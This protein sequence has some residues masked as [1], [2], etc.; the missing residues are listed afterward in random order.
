MKLPIPKDKLK[1]TINHYFN[2]I[3]MRPKIIDLYGHIQE[4]NTSLITDMSNM[5]YRFN[6][7]SNEPIILNWDTSNVV[8]MSHM[9]EYCRQSFILLFNNTSKV[10]DMSYM[11]YYNNLEYSITLD[12]SNVTNMS[13]MFAYCKN[14][15]QPLNFSNTSN[16]INMSFMFYNASEFNQPLNFDT[17]SAQNMDKM[18]LNAINFNQPLNFD[19]SN[20]ITYDE[21]F[22]G[23]NY[24]HFICFKIKNNRYYEMNSDMQIALNNNEYNKLV[25]IFILNIIDQNIAYNIDWT[26]FNI[27]Q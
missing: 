14:F 16:V 13:Y 9:F 17:C 23:I 10:T 4:W 5:F 25:L 12:T 19:T 26:M 7:I 20:L 15:N 21:M 24:S 11:F 2:S 8:D 22:A 6:K 27:I 18:F 3:L 1:I